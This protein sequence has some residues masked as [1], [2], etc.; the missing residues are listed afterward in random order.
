M[1][2]RCVKLH[3]Q[4]PTGVRPSQ[5]CIA[6]TITIHISR[7]TKLDIFSSC[8]E[9]V[10]LYGCESWN[11]ARCDLKA[12]QVLINR[13]YATR[14]FGNKPHKLQLNWDCGLGTLCKEYNPSGIRKEAA[15]K[16]VQV[17]HGADNWTCR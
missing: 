7:R 11:L 12:M 16:A 9:I 5:P 6:F 2:R 1:E 15:E 14:N 10:V 4:S 13:C 17:A 8:V 3:K